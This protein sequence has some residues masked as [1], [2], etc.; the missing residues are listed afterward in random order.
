MAASRSP[1]FRWLPWVVVA[2]AIF[3]VWKWQNT[4]PPITYNTETIARGTLEDAFSATGVL[5]AKKY[6]DIGAQVSGVLQKIDVQLGQSVE[7]GDLL[8]EIDP[9]L[10][11]AQVVQDEATLKN[12]QAQMASAEATLKLAEERLTRNR[13]LMKSDAT[14]QDEL[15]AAQAD[16]S[17]AQADIAAL[18]AQIDK[19]KGSLDASQA[20]L[21]YTKLYAP[22]SGT[23]VLIQ[24]REGSTL[25]ASQSAPILFRLA[26]LDT[27]TV[28]A[29]VSEADI[30]R[31][32]LGM[33]VYF[34]TLGDP[35]TH[36]EGSVSAVEP[37][38]TNTN[39][40]VFYNTL[41]DVPN[42]KR[43]LMPQMTAQVYFP[44]VTKTNVLMM[45]LAAL[46]FAE[47]MAAVQ[48]QKSSPPQTTNVSFCDVF[49]L[50]DEKPLERHVT[51]GIKNRVSAEVLSGLAEGEEIIT[52]PLDTVGKSHP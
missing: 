47:H 52:G 27:M 12:L 45:P 5:E 16:Y 11:E 3:A 23:V 32:H 41:F 46:D 31:V 37:S 38:S 42:E 40:P 34:T 44:M 43:T 21:G 33:P 8:A 17:R 48:Q 15:D 22:I 29:Q 2:G 10:F 7:K 26:N 35:D 36:H 20:N 30:E 1:I 6:V 4:S 24:A 19:A 25:N 39:P 13:N 49:V 14:S 18:K 51:L 28:E 9:S 50:H